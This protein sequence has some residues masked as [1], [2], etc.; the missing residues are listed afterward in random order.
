MGK[1]D[2]GVWFFSASKTI[3]AAFDVA[4]QQNNPIA[5]DIQIFRASFQLYLLLL[6][7][8]DHYEAVSMLR[9]FRVFPG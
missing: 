8:K 9:G 2:N 1:S 7:G 6:N 4:T 3:N 5:A